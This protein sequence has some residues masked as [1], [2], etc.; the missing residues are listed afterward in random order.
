NTRIG[1]HIMVGGILF[2]LVAIIVLS[3]LFTWV[4]VRTFK[5]CGTSL[6]YLRV[7]LIIAATNYYR[8][9][10]LLQGWEAYLITTE[11]CFS[12][13]DRAMI[14]L[15]VGIFRV[16]QLRWAEMGTQK[17]VGN[18]AGGSELDDLQERSATKVAF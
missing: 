12:A 6:R 13:L 7:C 9:I 16:A 14:V 10:E 4:M 17:A 8:T 5:T 2:Q 1:T 3:I 18:S 15:A 11:R